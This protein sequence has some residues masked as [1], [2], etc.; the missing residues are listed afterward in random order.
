MPRPVQDGEWHEFV[1]LV[2]LARD[3]LVFH[4]SPKTS[5]KPQLAILALLN[6]TPARPPKFLG[7]VH[8]GMLYERPW[9]TEYEF[10]R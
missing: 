7:N 3:M 9:Y 6:P 10:G 5:H 4:T 8:G 2:D 1:R